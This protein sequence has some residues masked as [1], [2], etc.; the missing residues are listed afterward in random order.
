MRSRRASAAAALLAAFGL[1]WS[2][3]C[4]ETNER[5][6]GDAEAPGA[7]ATLRGGVV[8]EP[9]RLAIGQTA[10]VEIAVVTPPE[11]RVRPVAAPGPRLIWL[12]VEPER[13]DYLLDPPCPIVEQV[14]RLHAALNRA[15]SSR[16]GS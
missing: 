8:I 5:G 1:A 7:P 9:D 12:V 3:A 16:T 15:S 6:E 2:L 10:T 13:D 11:H 14:D 4:G